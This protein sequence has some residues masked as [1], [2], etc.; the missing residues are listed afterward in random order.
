MDCEDI[1]SQIH[2]TGEVIVVG[3]NGTT[4]P[5]N[6]HPDTFSCEFDDEDPQYPACDISSEEICSSCLVRL[7]GNITGLRIFWNTRIPRRI[8]W[9]ADRVCPI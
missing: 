3:S 5:L 6:F 2:Q 1:I 7:P 9:L 4:I 8:K